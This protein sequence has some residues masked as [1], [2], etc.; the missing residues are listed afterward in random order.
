VAISRGTAGHHNVKAFASIGLPAKSGRNVPASLRP[1]SEMWIQ[2]ELDVAALNAQKNRSI[3]HSDCHLSIFGTAVHSE[4]S[5]SRRLELR[6]SLA[7]SHPRDV[8]A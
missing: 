4:S 7:D 6:C 5:T 3:H 2:R 8:S 1:M